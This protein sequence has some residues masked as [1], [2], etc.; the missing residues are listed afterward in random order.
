MRCKEVFEKE[1]CIKHLRFVRQH[2]E[3]IIDLPEVKSEEDKKKIKKTKP[4]KKDAKPAK[5]SGADMTIPCFTDYGISSGSGSSAAGVTIPISIQP[6]VSSKE[7]LIDFLGLY[8]LSDVIVMIHT[9]KQCSSI[10]HYGLLLVRLVL[11]YPFQQSNSE[12]DAFINPIP[13]DHEADTTKPSGGNSNSNSGTNTTSNTNSA[14]PTDKSKTKTKTKM[15]LMY[16][17]VE[18][19]IHPC[20]NLTFPNLLCYLLDTHIQ[21]NQLSEQ[22]LLLIYHLCSFSRPTQLNFIEA[23]LPQSIHKILDMF[24]GVDMYMVALCE[25]CLDCLHVISDHDV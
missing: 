21:C 22:V 23:K 4:A 3:E 14:T 1:R 24:S 8:V 5:R 17:T 16:N 20:T 2:D 12:I 25:M 11:R 6:Y 7:K 19:H 9:H 10:V 13:S 18:E 15:E